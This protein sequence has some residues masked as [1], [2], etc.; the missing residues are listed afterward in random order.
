MNVLRAWIEDRLGLSAVT[1]FL[2]KKD[3]PR[4][5]HTFL[6]YTG[7]SILLFL[8]IQIVTG[9]LLG[10]YY[11]P[12]LAEANASVVRIMTEM[13]LGWLVRS[14]H[15]WSATF[16]IALVFAHLLGIAFTKAYRKPRE[17]T[18]VTGVL[19]LG[20]SLAFGFTGYLLPW[21]ELSLAAT[22]VGTDLPKALPVVGPWLTQVMRA[23]GDVTGDTLSRFFIFH[24]SVLPL[25]AMAF[26]GVHLFLVQRHGMSVPHEEERK[27]VNVPVLPFWPNF[28][29][30]EA[31]VWLV[32][33]GL[34]TTSAVLA[35]PGIGPQADLMAPAP[36]GIKP[37]WYFL[38]MFQTLKV[39]PARVLGLNGEM[40]AVLI[41][42]AGMA[43][44]LLLPFIDNRPFERKGKV[45]TAL[46]WT[47]LAY[48]IGMS[49]WSLL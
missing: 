8:V 22:K 45:I 33:L 39:F 3:V 10:F 42:M 6:Y 15:S 40:F 5:K 37:E 17:A 1:G 49:I 34:L 7:S 32:L 47:G 27:G 13:P 38:F 31:G 30:R 9:V 46:A 2:A 24:V 28:A 36:Q 16:M 44:L 41:M 48:A 11:Q 23:G 21:D 19:L 26:I 29:F 25:A 14:V 35:A 4:H 43:A 20:A 12:T 18:W